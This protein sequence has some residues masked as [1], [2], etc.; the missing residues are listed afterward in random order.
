MA[1]KGPK[2]AVKVHVRNDKPSKPKTARADAAKPGPTN[3][4]A[5]EHHDK[6]SGYLG[7]FVPATPAAQKKAKAFLAKMNAP[8]FP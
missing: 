1:T 8:V 7:K 4:V 5:V 2:H 3:F 6:T